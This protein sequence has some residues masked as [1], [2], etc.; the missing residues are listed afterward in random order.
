MEVLKKYKNQLIF[1]LLLNLFIAVFIS[2]SSYYHLPLNGIKDYFSYGVHFLL[3]Q[4]TLFGFC[5][6]GTLHRYLFR[7]ILVPVLLFFSLYAYWI[8]T[9]DISI[10]KA[11]IQATFETKPDIAVD[12][13]TT[14]F[15][16]Y[17]ASV[18]IFL[19]L[20]IR[21]Q[22]STTKKGFNIPFLILALI[23]MFVFYKID[24]YRYHTFSSRMPYSLVTG[25]ID[26]FERPNQ[27]LSAIT[28]EITH[29]NTDITVV[30]VLGESV[31]A[32][33]LGINGYIRKT[34]PL[35]SSRNNIISFD[36]VYTPLTYTSISLPQI[37]TNE[38]IENTPTQ[39]TYSIY[40]VL[41]KIG[42]STS[43]I[44]NQ[45]PEKSYTSFISQNNNIQLID[46]YHSVL[47]FHKKLD[48]ALIPPLKKTLTKQE[49]QF[50]TLHMIG[51]H[52][53]YEN[54][55]SEEFRKYVPVIDSKHIPSLSKEQLINSYDNTIRY[56]D[57]FLNE[58]I[59]KL[60]K[61]GKQTVLIY[62]SDHG[63]ALGE[64]NKWLHAQENEASKN[65]AMLV[66]YSDTFEKNNPL[67]VENLAAN[68]TKNIT[69]DFL[70]HS[71]LDLIGVENF[72]Y[73]KQNSIFYSNSFLKN[74]R[75]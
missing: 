15:I 53:W 1:Q 7:C 61:E 8:Y 57:F 36:K 23:A 72:E 16:I 26:Y 63:E 25:I 30:L 21:K 32:D 31:R 28:R 47:S 69:T 43:W 17:I 22:N 52:W 71:V 19:F 75:K 59:H 10:T 12:L 46:P 56:L 5:Y 29:K 65:P 24:N 66:W 50:V 60:E 55:Y 54:R 41:N 2:F 67:F 37:L 18:L 33:H 39:N 3:I 45:S 11:I 58:T 70:Y 42:M 34:T 51:S 44:G 9:Q 49:S 13:L 74:N 40:S 64:E 6:I 35:L 27:K 68:S 14:P 38:S 4:F 73:Q 20:L 62:L 48:A